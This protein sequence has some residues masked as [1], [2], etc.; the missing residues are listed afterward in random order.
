[1]KTT[2]RERIQRFYNNAA[3][4]GLLPGEADSLRRIEM[5]LHRWAEWECGME[6]GHIERDEMTGKPW[7]VRQGVRDSIRWQIADREAGALRRLARIMAS[8]PELLAYHQT[9]P[10]GCALYLLRVEDVK[11]GENVSAVY[12]RGWAVTE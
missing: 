8:H 2:K 4:L 1:M 11:P 3:R 5:T 9:D 6:G 12:S 7:M 10:R